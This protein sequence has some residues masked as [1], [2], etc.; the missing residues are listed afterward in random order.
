M[1]YLLSAWPLILGHLVIPP[2]SFLEC[3]ESPP[4]DAF[5]EVYKISEAVNP[6]LVNLEYVKRLLFNESSYRT[7]GHDVS[8]VTY[9]FVHGD[10]KHLIN[11][12]SAALTLGHPLW[13]EHGSFSLYSVFL[14]GGILSVIPTMFH[15]LQHKTFQRDI[16]GMMPGTFSS[17]LHM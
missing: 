1:D 8:M 4:F 17:D 10:Y 16:S 6:G 9:M 15:D 5:Y 3:K 11:N 7:Q 2:L 14:L 12:T 13:K